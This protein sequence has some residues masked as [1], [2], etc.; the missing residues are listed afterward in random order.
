MAT[1]M[2][3]ILAGCPQRSPD[4]NGDPNDPGGGPIV[5]GVDL[6][7]PNEGARH[8]AQGTQVTYATNPPASGPHWPAPAARGFYDSVVQEEAWVHSLEHGYVVLLFDCRGDCD[9]VLIA[10]LQQFFADAPPSAAFGHAK[11]VLTPYSGLPEGALLTVVAW[12]HQ[13]HLAAFDEPA[14]LAFFNQYQDQGPEH[15]P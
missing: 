3:L 9:P 11:L 15:V 10:Q 8:V 5:L 14:I 1:L 7:I 13:L 12:D 6:T 2:G 4:G